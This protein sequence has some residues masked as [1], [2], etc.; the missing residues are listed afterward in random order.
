MGITNDSLNRLNKLGFLSKNQPYKMLE[1]GCQNIYGNEFGATYGM[2][3]K[4]FF[5]DLKIEHTSWDICG[6][7]G[8]ETV[9]L[10]NKIDI[11]KTGQFDVI[12]DFGTTEHIENIKSGGYYEAMKNIHNLCKVGGYRVH[13]TPMTGHWIGHGFNYLTKDFYIQLAKDNGYQILDLTEHYAMGNTTDGGL[14]CCVLVKVEEK[15]F[16]SKKI[17]GT[18]EVKK[19]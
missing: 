15:E 9:D 19:S 11:S 6:C 16:V 1:L 4:D 7:Q 14:I 17:F 2:I 5:V 12:T 8:S 3:A 18:Y 10:R 13:E